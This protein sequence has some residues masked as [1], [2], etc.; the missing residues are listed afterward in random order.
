MRFGAAGWCGGDFAGFDPGFEF[1]GAFADFAE[2]A[3]DGVVCCT[4][5]VVRMEGMYIGVETHLA[6]R[7]LQFCGSPTVE[8]YV[9]EIFSDFFS[10]QAGLATI[11]AAFRGKRPHYD[12]HEKT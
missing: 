12:T 10:C 6:R 2:L 7:K 9:G 11:A 1:F 3:F 8:E 5:C 4:C